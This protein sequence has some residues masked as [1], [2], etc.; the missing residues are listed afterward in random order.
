MGVLLG[1]GIGAAGMKAALS[2]RDKVLLKS[3]L[4]VAKETYVCCTRSFHTINAS[5]YSDAG[6]AN[7]DEV[8]VIEIFRG[9][10]L[11]IRSVIKTMARCLCSPILVHQPSSVPS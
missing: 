6:T 9:E 10:F 8:F 4:Q 11:D 2:A 5:L 1:W 7:P 3:S